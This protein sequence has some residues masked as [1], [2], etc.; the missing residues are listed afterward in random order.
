MEAMRAHFRPEFLN[1]VDEIVIFH[2]LGREQLRE[3]AEIQLDHVRVLL[4]GR[5]ITL[6]LTEAATDLLISEGYDPVYGARPLKRV[7]QR[8]VIDPLAMKVIRGD[9]REGDHVVAEA[10]GDELEFQIVEPAVEAA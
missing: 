6:S 8:R 1:R 4:A 9:I 7:L 5:H 2:R 3:I 10:A